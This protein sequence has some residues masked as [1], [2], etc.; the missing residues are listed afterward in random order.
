VKT[1][2]LFFALQFG[3]YFLMTVNYRAIGHARYFWTVLTDVL[4]ATAQFWLIRKVGAS[5][6][7]VI[8]WGGVVCGGATGSP[9][10][11]YVSNKLF[12]D[13]PATVRA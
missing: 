5:P 12:G 1:F 10:G 8:A 9:A 7:T 13:P 11:I 2:I 6:E 3:L 4:I